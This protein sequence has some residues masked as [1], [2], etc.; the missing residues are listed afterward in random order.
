MTAPDMIDFQT[1]PDRYKHWR[2][3]FDGHKARLEMDVDPEAPFAEGYELKLNS[4]DLGVDIELADAIQRLRFEHPEVQ[5]LEV[6]SALDRVFCAGANIRM[7]AASTHPFKVNFCKYTNETRIGL[8]D[9]AENSGVATVCAVNGPCAGGGYELALACE[10][11][12]LV[13]DGNSTVSLPEVPLL[14]VLPGT[15][16]L[17]RL[18][19]KR[20]VRRDL[21]D[22]FSTL[23]EGVR[24][25]KAMQWKLVDGS[26]K[27]S[28]FRAAMD[29]ILDHKV[30]AGSP[31]GEKGLPLPPL[32]FERDENGFTYQYLRCSIDPARRLAELSIHGPD[33]AQPETGEEYLGKGADAWAIRAFRELDDLLCHLRFEYPEI[34]LLLL[35]AKGD[36]E[37]ILDIE[38]KLL[39]AR[40]HWLINEILLNMARVCRRFELSARSL[41]ALIEPDSAFAGVLYELALGCDRIY[42]MDDPD[43]PAHL[44]IGPL[45]DGALPMTN[46]LTRLQS[47][48]LADPDTAQ[49]LQKEQPHCDGEAANELGLVTF[50]VEDLD[51]DDD[52]R[53][54]IE[55][56]ATLSPDALTGMEASLRFGGAET[57]DSKIFGRL[58]AWQNWIFTRPNAVGETG[59]LVRYGQPEAASFDWRRT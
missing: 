47:R 41:F 8:E 21:A 48:F 4:Y 7:L 26:Y 45:S 24:G 18:V 29:Q 49:R 2:L 23:A 19:D 38:R 55:E 25:K 56:R 15:G 13:D 10:E 31:R 54:A 20:K 50:L 14:G 22:V 12:H 27:T 16:G 17:T 1:S 39:A 30:A 58:S 3:S 35:R 11:I 33:E 6:T 44:A 32:D 40:E 28:K 34:G 46:G 53:I 43:H 5:V 9:L 36:R 42:M 57:C 59:A 52:L 51:W 37:A